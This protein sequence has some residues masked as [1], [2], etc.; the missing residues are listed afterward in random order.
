MN[1]NKLVFHL[2]GTGKVAKQLNINSSTISN[3]KKKNLIPKKYH[4]TISQLLND[5]TNDNEETYFENETKKDLKKQKIL[6]IIT[7][8]IACYKSLELIRYFKK[9]NFDVEVILTNSAQKFIKPLLI[10]SLTGKKCFTSLFS[11]EDE[12]NMG[13]IK[14]ARKNDL[15]IVA[16]ATA[17]FI[18]K[19]AHGIADDLAT[20]VM[21]ATNN[22]IILAP[23]M[24]PH[25]WVNS[26]TQSNIEK[27]KKRD[28]TIINPEEGDT[29]CGEIGTG[30]LA[31]VNKIFELS[32]HLINTN[33]KSIYET[34]FLKKID[35]LEVLITAGP[36]LEYIDP[37]RYVSN[38]SSGKQGYALAN[39]FR[40]LGAKVTL[41][42]GP[43]NLKKPNVDKII[44]VNTASEM[45]KAVFLNLPKHIFVSAA[46]VSDYK[47]EPIITSESKKINSKIKLK[48]NII[49]EEN[50][51]FK[52]IENPDIL[53]EVSNCSN[54]PDLVVGFAA[55]TNNLINNAKNKLKLKNLD[56]IVANKID[57]QNKVFG[58]DINSV[59]IIDKNNVETLDRE[60]KIYIANCIA[61][62]ITGMYF[63]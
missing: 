6:L 60:S 51:Y 35:N 57:S 44:S 16:P 23:S 29:A 59:S 4:E 14:L 48:K 41:I 62:K 11:E 52:P 43:T 58:E 12:E 2:G 45:L 47:L 56:L 3:W 55:E 46:A 40:E 32:L 31:D 26:A 39:A 30:R 1:V 7:G 8:G 13:H 22:R 27:L 54:R 10:T 15:I 19:I 5:K 28:M 20:N 9:K 36:T 25:M 34:N 49:L 38:N 50:F 17:N 37:I 21:L 42:T 33:S 53:Y 24:N 18:A 61:K 63:N